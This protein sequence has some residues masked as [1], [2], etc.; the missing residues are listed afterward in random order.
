MRNFYAS[1][2]A[3][4][5]PYRPELRICF[6]PFAPINGQKPKDLTTAGAILL[7]QLDYWFSKYPG[8]F[9]KFMEPPKTGHKAYRSGDSWTEELYFSRKEFTTAFEQVGI[10]YKSKGQFD[11]ASRAGDVFHGRFYCSYYDRVARI[12]W[13]YRNHA[14]IDAYLDRVAATALKSAETQDE[15]REVPD[16]QDGKSRTADQAVLGNDQSANLERPKGKIQYTETTLRDYSAENTNTTTTPEGSGGFSCSSSTSSDLESNA[17]ICADRA[18]SL[19]DAHGLKTSVT[20]ALLKACKGKDIA[21]VTLNTLAVAEHH[22]TGKP[23]KSAQAMLTRALQQNWAPSHGSFTGNG[24]SEG[25]KQL[26]VRQYAIAAEKLGYITEVSFHQDEYFYTT[27]GQPY[28]CPYS[29]LPLMPV[30]GVT[31]QSMWA[32]IQIQKVA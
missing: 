1:N 8:G 15:K 10:A 25:G 4:A 28:R 21:T 6:E 31:L 12:T 30:E 13:Y 7:Q 18:V 22:V 2:S 5:I 17:Q 14:V 11:Q 3:H 20:Q 26:Y 9:Y 19:M 24:L 23:I 29:M 27:D 16:N 32:D